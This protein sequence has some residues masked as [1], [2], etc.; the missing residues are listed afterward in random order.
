MKI[1]LAS[2]FNNIAKTE[3]GKKYAVAI[4]DDNQFLTN[5]KKYIPK[6][7]SAVM[8]ANDPTDFDT[9]DFYS[10]LLFQSLELSGLDF[11]TKVVFDNRNKDLAEEIFAN[12]DLIF[13]AGGKVDVQSVFFKDIKMAKLLRSNKALIVGGSAGAMNLCETVLN[14]PNF[15]KGIGLCDKIIVPHFDGANKSYKR[16]GNDEYDNLMALS[17]NQEL[18]GIDEHSYLLL[19]D[20]EVKPFGNIYRIIDKICQRY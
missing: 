2:S 17:V 7:D 3:D 1:I 15:I 4:S 11:K 8:V 18:I 19:T 12:A 10:D 6:F 14:F 5:L 9:T 13:L 20:K 16:D